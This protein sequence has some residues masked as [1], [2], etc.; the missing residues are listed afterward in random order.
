MFFPTRPALLLVAILPIASLLQCS[1]PEQAQQNAAQKTQSSPNPSST[2]AATTG[3][4]LQQEQRQHS[5]TTPK[6]P[7]KIAEFLYDS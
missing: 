1:Q 2:P 4:A 7:A 6:K 5:K 3:D